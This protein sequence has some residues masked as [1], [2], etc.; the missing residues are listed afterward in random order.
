MTNLTTTHKTTRLAA[1]GLSAALLYS[2]VTEAA[3]LLKPNNASY[4]D[5]QIKTHH[6]NVVIEDM[7]A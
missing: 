5:L 4:A 1:L 7:Y 6:V 3:G 2:P